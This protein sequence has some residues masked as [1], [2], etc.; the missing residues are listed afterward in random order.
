MTRIQKTLFFIGWFTAV[1]TSAQE[2]PKDSLTALISDMA[3][4]NVYE[5]SYTVGFTGEVSKQ[6]QRFE[7]LTTLATEQQLLT[8]AET[9]RNAVV[10]LYAFQA[11]KKGRKVIPGPLLQQFR[12]DRTVVRELKGCVA[13]EKPVNLLFEQDLK[14]PYDL[15][16]GTFSKTSAHIP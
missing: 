1:A 8:L 9:H 7:R 16:D 4:S 6:I 10:R 5:A 13:K 14:S 12:N 2:L 15:P 3:C 11:L